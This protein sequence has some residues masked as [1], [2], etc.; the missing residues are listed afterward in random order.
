MVTEK[1][2]RS[3]DGTYGVLVGNRLMVQ[4]EGKVPSIDTL[5]QAVNAV[6]IERVEALAR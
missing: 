2:D 1:W 6:G 3:G 4:A 5:K